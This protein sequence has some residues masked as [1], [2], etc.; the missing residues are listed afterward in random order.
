[1]QRNATSKQWAEQLANPKIVEP[2]YF[3]I[4]N[5]D[6]NAVVKQLEELYLQELSRN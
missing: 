4:E 3:G 2:E 6:M 1:M 5:W